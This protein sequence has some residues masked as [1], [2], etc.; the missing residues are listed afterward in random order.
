MKSA[1]DQPPVPL[2]QDPAFRALVM[3]SS[4]LGLG[5]M[6][7][8]LTLLDHG[9]YGF[10]FHW[11]NLAIPAFLF[12]ALVSSAYWW[13]VF[14]FTASSAVGGGRRLMISASVILLVLAVVAFLYPARFIPADKR[15]DVMIGLGAAFV[16]LGSIAYVIHTIVRWLDQDSETNGD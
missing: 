6:V 14:R 8:S 16:V 7:S 10:E 3:V 9:P 4:A 12:G 15:T 11:S 2:H 5:C 1:P 13:L